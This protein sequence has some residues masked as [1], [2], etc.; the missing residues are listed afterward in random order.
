MLLY[1]PSIIVVLASAVGC[2]CLVCAMF[3]TSRFPHSALPAPGTSMP[4]VT[5]L[6]PLHGAEPGLSENLASFC[7]QNYRSAVQIILGVQDPRDDAIAVVEQLRATYKDC[8]L[9][10][11]VD[12][13]VHGLNRKV[14][15]LINMWRYVEH[16]VVVVADS[17]MRV[18]PDYLS[19]VVAALEQRGV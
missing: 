19:R 14:S 10:L 1:W 4:R 13:T 3:L 7:T 8:R 12:A 9:D 18:D 16:D 11:V 15:N 17:D 5:I 6:K 2:G